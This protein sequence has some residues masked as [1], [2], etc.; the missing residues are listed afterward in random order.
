MKFIVTCSGL[1]EA[2]F[3]AT[4]H[5]S[6]HE[7]QNAIRSKIYLTPPDPVDM[8]ATRGTTI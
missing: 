4:D 2:R 5:I 1:I 3:N 7:F 8:I 6:V